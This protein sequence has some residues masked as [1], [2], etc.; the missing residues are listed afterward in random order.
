MIYRGVTAKPPAPTLDEMR[1]IEPDRRRSPGLEFLTATP[2]RLAVLAVVLMAAALA[3]GAVTAAAIT[4]RQQRIQGLRANSEP[5]ADTAQVLYS[6]LSIADASATSAFLAGGVE[7]PD[8]RARYD[9]AIRRATTALVAASN[10]VSSGDVA[11]ITLLAQMSN[12]LADYVR[13]VDTARANNRAGNPLG[14]AY[15]GQ[16]SGLM[17]GTILPLAERMYTSQSQSVAATQ[18]DTARFPLAPVLLAAAVLLA[19]VGAQ[20]YVFRLSR[21]RISPGLATASL[22]M[23]VLMI[24]LTFAAM[25]STAA[26]NHARDRG[27]QPLSVVVQARIL[28]QRARADETLALLRHGSNT[29]VEADFATNTKALSSVLGQYRHRAPSPESEPQIAAAVGALDGWLTVHGELQQRLSAGDFPGAAHIATGPEPSGAT[30]HVLALDAALQAEIARLRSVEFDSTTAAYRA[31]LLLPTV[32]AGLA[33]LSALFVAA[34][35]WPR[36]NEYQ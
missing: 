28:A 30:A 24:W 9:D 17:Q 32:G 16:A 4:D 12:R 26:N 3:A 35:M 8:L 10:G 19:L 27:T 11:T 25:A 2:G 22:L 31:L 20:L 14:V 34:G 33:V 21:R 18:T 5:L 1:L 13:Q 6:S 29:Q 36:L 23:A 15:L 7:P